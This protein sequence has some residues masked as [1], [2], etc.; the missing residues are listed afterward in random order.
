VTIEVRTDYPAAGEVATAV[1]P[2]RPARFNLRIRVPGWTSRFEA[3]CSDGKRARGKAGSFLELEREWRQGDTVTLTMEMPVAVLHGGPPHEGF[4][5]LKRGPMFLSLGADVNPVLDIEAVRLDAQ[6]VPTLT[7][8]ERC[9]PAN[10][11]GGQ[12]YACPSVVAADG[13][14]PLLVPFADTGQM[15]N[16]HAYRVWIKA[17]GG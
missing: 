15:C 1:T 11:L 10:W 14:Q 9:L 17:A 4:Y 16:R 8:M 5:A 7:P 3:V 6:S 12:A 13:S 2:A